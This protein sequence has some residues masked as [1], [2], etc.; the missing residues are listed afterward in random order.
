MKISQPSIQFIKKALKVSSIFGIESIVF[1]RD[2][3]RGANENKNIFLCHSTNIPNFEFDSLGVAR[4]PILLAR[5]DLVDDPSLSVETIE[6]KGVI[7]KLVLRNQTTK[8]EFGCA[9]SSILKAPRN[10]NDEL[11]FSFECPSVV[12]KIISKAQNSIGS[13]S[14]TLSG[15][16]NELKIEMYDVTD[17]VFEH[18][19]QIPI[20]KLSDVR[21]FIHRYPVKFITTLFKFDDI[22]SIQISKRGFIKALVHDI[23]IYIPPMI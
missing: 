12:Q 5:L 1:E 10:I 17:D 7:S 19:I 2:N 23:T 15:S 3:I 4:L 6:K 14:V 16:S 21:T 8:V 18:T 20:T 9:N 13:E 11:V 22:V